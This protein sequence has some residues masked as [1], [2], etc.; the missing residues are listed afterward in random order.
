MESPDSTWTA[1]RD[2]Q[3]VEIALALFVGVVV[4]LGLVIPAAVVAHLT[5]LH[6]AGWERVGQVG[7]VLAAVAGLTCLVGVLRPRSSG[8]QVTR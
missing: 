3:C 8:P 4:F 6:G 7:L 5:G 1:R 2:A